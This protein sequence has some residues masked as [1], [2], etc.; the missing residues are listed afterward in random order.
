MG[1]IGE[2]EGMYRSKSVRV[3]G[4]HADEV[5]ECE[6]IKDCLGFW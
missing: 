4:L 3:R 5:E 1:M 2:G 6:I